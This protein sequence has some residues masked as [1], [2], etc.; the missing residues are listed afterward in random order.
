MEAN[1]SGLYEVMPVI[2]TELNFVGR[3]WFHVLKSEE[4]CGCFK[5]LYYIILYNLKNKVKHKSIS[6][7]V[8][9]FFVMLKYHANIPS[10]L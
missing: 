7:S 5:S 9:S 8:F 4:K 1:V 6:I 2:Y 3:S 10:Y